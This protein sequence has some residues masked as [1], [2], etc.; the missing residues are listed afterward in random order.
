MAILRAAAWLVAGPHAYFTHW[1]TRSALRR[2]GL[3]DAAWYLETYPDV[4]RAGREPLLHYAQNGAAEGRR[5]NPCFDIDWYLVQCP[6]V[7][8][9]RLNPLTHYLRRGAARGLSP[10]PDV[11]PAEFVL[12]HPEARAYPTILHYLVAN[13]LPEEDPA[14]A[15][16]FVR[17]GPSTAAA[18]VAGGERRVCAFSHFDVGGRVLGYVRHYLAA[19]AQHGFEIHF[20]ST[21]PRLDAAEREE[22]EAGGVRVHIRENRGRDF[23]SW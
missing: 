4:A 15:P 18:V 20:I 12:R 11:M 9:L 7:A 17:T 22:L 2:S 19:L 16:A 13:G 3:F 6:H 14:A 8:A 21:A 1:A 10:H 23:G 5:P